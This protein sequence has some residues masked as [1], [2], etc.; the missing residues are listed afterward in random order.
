MPEA[1][2]TLEE[3]HTIFEDV[4]TSVQAVNPR[5]LRSC[6][7]ND[8]KRAAQSMGIL[9]GGKIDAPNGEAS[10]EMVAD[11]ALFE[12][13]ERGIRPVDRF[14]SGPALTLSERDQDIARRMGR[15]FFSLF[16]LAG[17]HALSGTWVE[18]ILDNDRR[19]WLLDLDDDRPNPLHT[20]A[21]RVFDAGPFHLSLCV[22]TLINERMLNVF[23]RAHATGRRPWRRSLVATIY[24]LA[25]LNGLP[26]T[27][28]SGR[29]F[30]DDLG[31]ELRPGES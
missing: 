26:P 19:I 29:K 14:P 3:V 4:N 10:Y 28:V 23:K 16:R 15:S 31:A 5:M 13:N 25:Q 18:D 11:L 20:F 6:G 9:V 30:V 24:G 22:I 8:L 7:P 17:Q 27:H 21:G 1:P 12:P 2:T